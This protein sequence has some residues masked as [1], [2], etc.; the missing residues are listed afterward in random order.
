MVPVSLFIIGQIIF[1]VFILGASSQPKILQQAKHEVKNVLGISQLA[2]DTEAPSS[3][4]EAPAAEQL[5]AAEP[6][7]A[8]PS[9]NPN[10]PPVNE[11]LPSTV[12]PQPESAA[13]SSS[14][15]PEA[16]PPAVVSPPGPSGGSGS[17]GPTGVETP[18]S[19][20]ATLPEETGSVTPSPTANSPESSVSQTEAILNPENVA[21]NTE[22]ID[23]ESVDAVKKEDDSISQAQTS[24]EKE[25]LLITFAKDKVNDIEKNLKEDDFTTTAFATT[26][27]T[28][29]IDRATQ[30]IQQA[31]PAQREKLTQQVSV[32]CREAD[33]QLKNQQ[34]SVPEESEQDMEI[35]RAKCFDYQ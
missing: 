11:A 23:K 22:H 24:D 12:A 13:G 20:P 31:P 35:S 28:D 8:E 6:P 3:P 26:R 21:N 27:L 17:P 25:K 7:H 16:A 32:F 30:Q 5:P 14:P 29:E 4:P 10:P 1:T 19:L 2:Q 34:L 9:S 33:L 18:T 15:T